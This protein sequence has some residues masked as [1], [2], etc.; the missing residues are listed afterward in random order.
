MVQ[1]V[2]PY[3]SLIPTI[4]TTTG[5][6]LPSLDTVPR[7]ASLRSVGYR[8]YRVLGYRDP[9]TVG[10]SPCIHSLT[11]CTLVSIP[12]EPQLLPTLL[13]STLTSSSTICIGGALVLG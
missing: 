13:W 3:N 7:V 2:N 8:R 6:T 9:Y 12:W 1:G 5:T 10:T 11:Y 4:P